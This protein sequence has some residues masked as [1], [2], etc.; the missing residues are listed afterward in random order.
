M[1]DFA[2][3]KR[4]MIFFTYDLE[5][6]RDSLR[7]FY[8]DFEKVAPGKIAMT[9]DEIV[10]TIA[11]IDEVNEEYKDRYEAFYNKFCHVDNGESAKNIVEKI[12][13]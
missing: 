1:F 11:N 13:K 6:Y 2:N 8:F 7:G 5:K 12:F 9:T 4:P 3:L 10:D